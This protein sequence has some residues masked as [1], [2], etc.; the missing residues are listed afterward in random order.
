MSLLY[1][2]YPNAVVR[3]GAYTITQGDYGLYIETSIG[4][5][6][7]AANTQ[8]AIRIP[9][10]LNVVTGNYL[11]AVFTPSVLSNLYQ[12][13][14]VSC[15]YI[16]WNTVNWETS[17]DESSGTI[18]WT[19]IDENGTQSQNS[20]NLTLLGL[21]MVSSTFDDSGYSAIPTATISSIVSGS[22]SEPAS[23]ESEAITKARID[24]RCD[25]SRNNPNYQKVGYYDLQTIGVSSILGINRI[26]LSNICS[27]AGTPSGGGQDAS[28]ALSRLLAAKAPNAIVYPDT[29]FYSW[30]SSYSENGNSG[31]HQIFIQPAENEDTTTRIFFESGNTYAI[32]IPDYS[33]IKFTVNDM[34]RFLKDGNINLEKKELDKLNTIFKNYD[35]INDKGEQKP[36]G[37]LGLNE[38]REGFQNELKKSMPGVFDKLVE[39]FIIL[40][41]VEEK[42]AENEAKEQFKNNIEKAKEYHENNNQPKFD[43][44]T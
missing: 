6:D 23:Q 27:R 33:D 38:D 30:A 39:F 41:I 1:S 26:S 44:K 37:E 29:Q 16:P 3:E 14:D 24:I 22:W 34:Q 43:K 8:Y 17:I 7:H 35:K 13:H 31:Y 28:T 32:K 36:D 4:A 42:R 5:L 11:Y 15:F 19:D 18:Y 10:I 20:Y 2:T 9:D 25:V 12:S 21:N 40:D